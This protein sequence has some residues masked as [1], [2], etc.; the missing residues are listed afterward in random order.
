M[1]NFILQNCKEAASSIPT[2]TYVD[3][4]VG[5]SRYVPGS[6]STAASSN[7]TNFDSSVNCDPFTGILTQ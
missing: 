6:T 5:S 4:F 2:S 1:V 3:P 7:S